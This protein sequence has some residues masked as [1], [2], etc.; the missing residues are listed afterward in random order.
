MKEAGLKLKRSVQNVSITNNNVSGRAVVLK[1]M[2]TSLVLLALL[3]FFILG[4]MVFNIVERKN[5]EQNALTLSSQV[6]NLELSYL[7]VSNSI[8]SAMS[9]SMGFEKVNV[10]YATRK[11]FGF[12]SAALAVKDNEI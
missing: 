11:T 4:S 3:Y 1:S 6:G 9:A 5:L 7:A 8:D 2:L 10:S 12:N